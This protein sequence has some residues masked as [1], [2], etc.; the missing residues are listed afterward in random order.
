MRKGLLLTCLAG[1]FASYMLSS[2][3]GVFSNYTPLFSSLPDTDGSPTIPSDKFF[4]VKISDATFR[5]SHGYN[6][7]D[8]L[9]YERENGPG[10]DCKISKDER[11]STEDLY[12][13][14]EVLEGDLYYHQIEFEYNVPRGMCEYLS[15]QTHWHYNRPSGYGPETVYSVSTKRPS[16]LSRKYCP[17]PAPQAGGLCSSEL[18]SDCEDSSGDGEESGTPVTCY[19]HIEGKF[20]LSE[21][22]QIRWCPDDPDAVGICDRTDCKDNKETENLK[23]GICVTLENSNKC[24]EN[25]NDLCGDY[26]DSE[27]GV[28]CCLGEYTLVNGTDFSE[29]KDTPWGG[30]GL[31]KCI[32]GLG[33]TSWSI[34]T[35]NGL[36]DE[37]LKM[38]TSGYFGHYEVPPLKDSLEVFVKNKEIHRDK[39]NSLVIANYFEGIEDK[40]DLPKFYKSDPDHDSTSALTPLDRDGHPYITWS[41]EDSSRE[42]KHRIHLIIREWNTREEFEEF[43]TTAGS[44]G[45]PDI[46]DNEGN[47]CEYYESEDKYLK[48]DGRCNDMVDV[49]DWTS[50]PNNSSHPE[51]EYTEGGG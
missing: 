42:V 41:C 44:D 39:K 48:D 19:G 5:G 34:Y 50:T 22:V 31:K 16:S 20:C 30:T 1:V 28:N 32:G 49:D 21:Q 14:F 25:V 9:M 45:D 26:Y 43:K 36:P 46:G 10:Y 13:M 40:T 8:Y 35:K 18:Y 24:K 37:D 6:L 2:C 11:S 12:C 47:E 17:S 51:L 4:Y 15:F 38:V 7:L 33:R 23:K 3:S 29:K 27:E